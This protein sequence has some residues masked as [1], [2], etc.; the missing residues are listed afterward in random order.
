MQKVSLLL[1]ALLAISSPARIH[2][3]D[4]AAAARHK[5]ILDELNKYFQI[6]WDPVERQ[7]QIRW[8][9]E[10]K[11]ETGE[12]MTL[13]LS[14]F[15][16]KQ[17][18]APKNVYLTLSAT[19]RENR[20]ED[21]SQFKLRHDNETLTVEDIIPKITLT[22]DLDY[23][24]IIVISVPYADFTA[25]IHARE[26]VAKIGGESFDIT[27]ATLLEWQTL[28]RYF[29]DVAPRPRVPNDTTQM[30]PLAPKTEIY[31]K[32]Q[33]VVNRPNHQKTQINR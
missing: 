13:G 17:N 2:A 33:L 5:A 30:I 1:A 26:V 31:S 28:K 23:R 15:Y 7:S 21:S 16:S 18:P 24:T 29:K 9:K 10:G 14:A 11:L 20:F 4:P 6:T 12:T 27:P 8:T 25:I 19:T 3:A 22:H 32:L